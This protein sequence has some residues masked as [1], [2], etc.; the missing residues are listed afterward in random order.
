MT[1][2]VA[3]ANKQETEGS[4]VLAILDRTGDT[5][6]MWEVEDDTSVV[7]AAEAFLAKVEA[8][9]TAYA[10]KGDGA[11]PEVIKEF[12]ATAEK[13]ILTPQFVGG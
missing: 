12:D 8:G 2:L 10:L 9:Y 6:V 3:E 5:K 1:T 7:A 4:H 13:I 11:E